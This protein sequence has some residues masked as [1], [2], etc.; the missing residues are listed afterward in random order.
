VKPSEPGMQAL[1]DAEVAR[2]ALKLLAERKIVPTPETFAE[3]F[4]ESSGV[5]MRGGVLADVMKNIGA[6]LVRQARMTQQEAAQMLQA[7]LRQQW[8][9]VHDAIDRALARRP[10]SG[11]DAWPSMVLAILKQSDVLHANWTRARKLDSIARVVEAS[12]ADPSIALERLRRLVE[13]WG[14]PLAQLPGGAAAAAPAAVSTAAEPAAHLQRPRDRAE[15][16]AAGSCERGPGDHPAVARQSGQS[17]AWRQLALRAL[18]ALEQAC[19]GAEPARQKLRDYLAQTAGRGPACEAEP[20]LPPLEWVLAIE[21]EMAEEHRIRD[22]LQRLLG[23]LCHNLEQLAPDELWL[24]SQLE[25]VRA[26]LSGPIRSGQI[27]AAERRLAAL[28][29]KQAVARRGLQEAKVAL[30]EMLTTLLE[31][32]GAMGSSAERFQDQV[33]TYQ[34][35]LQQS[36]DP[37]T[38]TRIVHGLL[39]D[40]QTVRQQI[41]SSRT[42]LAE[43]RQKVGI[44]EAR[45]SQ[46]E[47]QLDEVSTLVQKDPLTNALNRRGLEHAFRVESARALRYESPL[48]LAMIDLDNF[49]QVNDRLGHVAGDR[50][51]IHFVTTVHATLRPTDLTARTGGEEFGVLFP[52]CSAQDG[53]EAIERLQRELARRPFQFEQERLNLTFSAGVSQWHPGETLEQLMQRADASL[54]EAKKAGKNRVLR[55]P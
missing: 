34:K 39:C 48:T 45:V 43:A 12:A 1:N 53:V 7:A 30:T 29:A 22:G 16:A 5:E 6:E 47:Q 42:E 51:L 41:E 2:R 40:T 35:Q 46:L 15:P 33:G 37:T 13:S 52:A 17:D 50:A 27:A 18:R 38:L 3:A 8:S 31:R 11:I 49:K 32:A 25:P 19:T 54:Y 4:R 24:T 21:R 28:I 55:A 26:L 36:P 23:L 14:P 20:A 10:G 44:Y 9:A